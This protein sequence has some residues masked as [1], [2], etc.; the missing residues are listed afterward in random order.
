MSGSRGT[1]ISSCRKRTALAYPSFSWTGSIKT[2]TK[3]NNRH[4]NSDDAAKLRNT[5]W[6]FQVS[7]FRGN[8]IMTIRTST[9]LL[10]ALAAIIFIV[11]SRANAND[12]AGAASPASIPSF[13]T[14]NI[15]REGHFY[16]GGH[17]TGQPGSEMMFGAMYVEVMVPKKIRHPYP[18]VFI[19][20]GAG[21]TAVTA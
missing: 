19:C 20:G 3:K 2:F 7:I 14:P 10:Y 16:V 21:Q 15:G 12:A 1:V 9:A 17:Y 11:S 8:Q 5:I 4:S 6:N 13:A 18:I